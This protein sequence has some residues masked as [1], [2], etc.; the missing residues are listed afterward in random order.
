MIKLNKSH[1]FICHESDNKNQTKAERKKLD[2]SCGS[3]QM[4][5]IDFCL[6]TTIDSLSFKINQF[7]D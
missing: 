7:H 6:I 2:M 4:G 1:L 5:H 3:D